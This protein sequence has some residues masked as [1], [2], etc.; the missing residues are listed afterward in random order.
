MVRN[1]LTVNEDLK[2]IDESLGLF[3]PER[4]LLLAI[5]GDWKKIKS[6]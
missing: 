4:T 1:W 5:G 2:K 6:N 3:G